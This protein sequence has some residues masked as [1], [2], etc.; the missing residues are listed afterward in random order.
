[1]VRDIVEDIYDGQIL[2]ELLGEAHWN[3]VGVRV[4]MEK[5]GRGRGLYRLDHTQ[6]W[7]RLK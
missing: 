3:E 2:G 5:E 4:C 1:M 6:D 7:C